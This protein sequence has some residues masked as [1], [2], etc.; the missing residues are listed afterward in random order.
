MKTSLL[1]AAIVIAGA[2]SAQM[3]Q[4]L[5][6]GLLAAEG[7]SSSSYPFATANA[8]FWHWNYDTSNFTVNYPI[9]IH[10]VSF[11]AN[12]GA[13]AVGGTLPIELTM[14]SSLV[15]WSTTGS[16]TTYATVMD[17]DATLVYSG[18]VTFPA[19]TNTTPAA[20]IP[21][22]LQ[23]PFL[24]D[25]TLGKDFILQIK[26][27]GPNS[28]VMSAIDLHSG[29]SAQRYGSQ[30]SATLA[31]ANFANSNIVG[32]CKIDFSPASG[33]YASFAATPLSG[34]APL[35][36]QFT[37]TSF[38]SDP[39]GITSY[40][41]DFD[42]DA[43][44]D[45]TLPNPIHTYVTPGAQT[46]TLTTTDTLHSPSTL[47]RPNLINVQQY[48]FSAV[49]SGAGFGDLTLTGVP[50]LGAPSSTE[51]YTFISFVVP[52]TVGTGPFFGLTPDA[53]TWSSFSY[54]A[55]PGFPLHYIRVPGV[56]PE[57]PLVVPPGTFSGFAGITIDFV[58]VGVTPAFGLAF[59]S[60]VSRA[61]F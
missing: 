28:A 22:T 48:L 7:S 24:Y 1:A 11:R 57:A 30:T 12:G 51:G 25:P 45:S 35:T 29:G 56:Y 13:T 37:N 39:A 21:V 55:A 32:V 5:P 36:V 15:D 53:A 49:T 8:N 17:T 47:T 60:N 44:V 33:L 61:T 27:A 2:V 50:G 46:V 23:T 38:T 9:L 58:Q 43:I 42:G 18:N 14:C 4:S 20:W 3:S 6:N 41:W 54:A 52:A 40:A 10:T 34:R 19:G 16:S 26:S 59:V 31:A